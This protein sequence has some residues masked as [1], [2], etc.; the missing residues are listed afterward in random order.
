MDKEKGVA[1]AYL[2]ALVSGISVFANSFGVLTLDPVAY[3]LAK[4]VLVAAILAA[5]GLAAGNWGEILAISRKQLLMLTFIGVVGGGVAFALFF[6]G[7]SQVSG[8]Y[9]SFLY[10][11]LFIFAAAIGVVA[12]KERFSWQLAAGALAVLAGNFVLLG[13]EA[14]VL[15]SGAMLVLA[16]TALWAAE[17]A[18]SK[19]AL[20]GLSATTVASAR[21]GLGS[22]VLLAILAAQ[23]KAGALSG[24]TPASLGWI[25]LATGLLALFT[26]LWYSALKNA[27]LSSATAALVL[28]GPISAFLGFALAGKAL[29]LLQ[30]GGLLL[31]VAGAIFAVGAGQTLLA[32]RWARERVSAIIRF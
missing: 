7:L 21:M 11:L 23:G 25:A 17:Y 27:S 30:A 14:I 24:I 6:T 20:E 1:L 18:V 29:T 28:G 22:L 5:I 19:K 32:A 10:R 26:T 13:S 3:T 4:N 9:G 12:L 2:T 31:L 8:A 16:A 15:G